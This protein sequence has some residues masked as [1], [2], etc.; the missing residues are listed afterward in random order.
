MKRQAF[1]FIRIVNAN[2]IMM[3]SCDKNLKNPIAPVNS[4]NAVV[5]M[6][7]G[8]NF[9]GSTTSAGLEIFVI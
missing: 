6:L 2:T 4:D 5:S 1:L 9:E 3:T 7:S 8:P